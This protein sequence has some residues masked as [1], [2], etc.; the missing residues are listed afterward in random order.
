MASRRVFL[1]DGTAFAYRAF[2]AIRQ[3]TTADGRPTNAVYG[4]AAMLQALRE[5]EQPDC[6]AVAFDVGKPTFRHRKFEAYKIQ[7]KPMPDPLISQLPLIKDLLVAYRIP[8]FEQAG[9]EAEDLLATLATQLVQEGAEV[10]LVTGDKDALQLVN[11]HIKVYNPHKDEVVLDAEAVQARYGVGPDRMVD[12]MALMGDEIDNIPGVPGIGEKTASQLLQRFGSLEALYAR[13]DEV[14]SPARRKSLTEFR[15]QVELARELARIDRQVPLTVRLEALQ[16]QEP[17]WRAL[18]K[19]FRELEFRR[20]LHTIETQA[21]GTTDTTSQTTIVDATDALADLIT[22]LN[23]QPTTQPIAIVAWPLEGAER[24]TGVLL[25]LATDPQHAWVVRLDE[26]ILQSPEGTRLRSWCVDASRPKISHDAK[27]MMRLFAS[28]QVPF[29]GLVGDTM[30]AA[31]LLNPARTNQSLSDL[32]DEYLD[33]PLG[34]LPSLAEDLA[35][36]SAGWESCGR[37]ASAVVRLH[38]RL[39][40][41]L[42]SHQLERLYTTLELPLIQVLAEMEMIGVAIDVPYLTGLQA[43]M[44]ATLTQ[45]TQEIYQLA[46]CTFNLNSPKQLAQVLFEQLKLPII[47]RTKTGASTDS[48]VLRQL[49]AQ[50]PLPQRLMD[51]RELAKLVSTYVEALPKLVDPKTGRLHTSLNQTAT[52]TGRLSSSEPN[53]QNIPVKT[54]LGR[55]IRRAF[56]AGMPEARLVAFDYSQIEL[57]ILAHLSG[58]SHLLNAFREE[59]DIH[60]FTASLIYGIPEAEVQ[61]EQ[62]NAMKAINYGILYGMTSHGLSKELGISFEESQA[63]IEAYFQRYPRVRAYLDEQI[64]HARRDGFVQTLLG[65]RRYIPEVNSPDGMVRQVGERMA[66]NAPIQGSAADLIKRAMVQI[67]EALHQTSWSSRMVLQVHD[68]L[69]FEVPHREQELLVALVR[70]IMEGAIALTVPLTVTVKA[71]P[72]WLD[73]TPVT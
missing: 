55:S 64:A 50:H 34:A 63:F 45:L 7:R 12:L 39:R 6:L 31:Y 17:D 4:F 13:L 71:G 72:N 62:R 30:V 42:E 73:L 58:D 32:S 48:D 9:Y 47:K 26:Q 61:P 28:W 16:I 23:A 27:T 15:E 40:G 44:A 22:R 10:F 29:A 70:R 2:Y 14:E 46:G 57:R 33:E 52:S 25:A 19:L 43:S 36:A 37:W 49:A 20:L 54:E 41:E 11:S 66:V 8:V 38:E 35:T 18:R 69:I 67:A 24:A 21:P 3:L 51:Y 56:I 5:K 1:I 65:R 59:R 68:E 60:R 53:L